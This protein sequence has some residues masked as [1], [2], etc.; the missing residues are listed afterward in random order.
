[1]DPDSTD[2]IDKRNQNFLEE[3]RQEITNGTAI[4]PFLGSGIS[5]SSGI[6]TGQ[7]FDNYL[8]YV[9]FR[10]LSDKD[11]WDVRRD[12]WPETPTHQ[13]VNDATN[14]LFTVYGD[15]LR[16]YDCV[17]ITKFHAES[18]LSSAASNVPIPA[19]GN[20]KTDEK[21]NTDGDRKILHVVSR[22]FE[23]KVLQGTGVTI[24]AKGGRMILIH[25]NDEDGPLAI[26]V[27]EEEKPHPNPPLH[28][29]I[30]RKPEHKYERNESIPRIEDAELLGQ[31]NRH[32]ANWWNLPLPER[33]KADT[34][35]LL[36][37]MLRPLQEHSTKAKPA[38][39]AIINLDD[40]NIPAPSAYRL[41][42]KLKRPLVPIILRSKE[43]WRDEI[44]FDQIRRDMNLED[45]P[46]DPNASASSVSYVT[47]KAIR[48]LSH[49][50][51]TLEFLSCIRPAEK[52]YN[53]W[54]DEPET[55]VIDSFNAHITRDRHPNLIHTMIARLSRNLRSRTILTTNFDTLIEQAFLA[56][57][58][59]LQVFAV[60][61]KG[62]LPHHATVRAQD[63]I[64]KLHG[65]ILET[66]AD[67]TI[68]EP[69]NE[70]DKERFFNYLRGGNQP[71]LEQ[72]REFI[73]SHLLVI[74]YSGNDARCIRMIKYVLDMDA[75]FRVFWICYNKDDEKRVK[76]L[77]SE[78]QT[79]TIDTKRPR[80]TIARTDQSDLFLW[81]LYQLINFSLPGG[82]VSFQFAH[83]IPPQPTLI[84]KDT[85]NAAKGEPE[86][87]FQKVLDFITETSHSPNISRLLTVD[88]GSGLAVDMVKAFHELSA[89]S[90]QPI[91]LELEDF[92]DADHLANTI[93][94]SISLKIGTFQT[95]WHIYPNSRN[96]KLEFERFIN[97]WRIDADRWVL[98][99]YARNGPGGCCGWTLD[100]WDSEKYERL[101]YLLS[102]LSDLNFR[103]IYLPFGTKRFER[104]KIKAS[105]I[106]N[107]PGIEK[108]HTDFSR[109]YNAWNRLSR[110]STY[111]HNPVTIPESAVD[112]KASLES[113]TYTSGDSTYRSILDSVL[114]EFGSSANPIRSSR[115]IWLYGM[116]LFR[117]SRH[118]T[119]VL[120][121]SV[122]PCPSRFGT[123]FDNDEIRS[124]ILFGL[125]DD[126]HRAGVQEHTFS[127]LRELLHQAGAT[128]KIELQ[129][130]VEWLTEKGLI[131]KKAGGYSW[132]YRDTRLGIQYLLENS[133][134]YTFYPNAL[135][136]GLPKNQRSD[137]SRT[138]DS[139]WRLRG[140]IHYWI[141][142][143]YLRAF[144]A[145]RHHT[146]LIEAIYHSVQSLIHSP[147]G[148][149]D[150]SPS[151]KGV[152]NR[153]P[154]SRAQRNAL[155]AL[156]Q[157][158]KLIRLGTNSLQFWTPGIELD[159]TYFK[160]L[161]EK[162][163]LLETFKIRTHFGTSHPLDKRIRSEYA[164]VS[165]EL[166][167]LCNS[168]ASEGAAH[169]K[170]SEDF[171]KSSR[172]SKRVE[173]IE[174]K[175]D[176]KTVDNPKWFQS[177]V[178]ELE[179]LGFPRL[180]RLIRRVCIEASEDDSGEFH[181]HC[182][183]ESFTRI[184]SIIIE[185]WAEKSCE[186]GELLN[187]VW[188]L[189]ELAYRSARRATLIRFASSKSPRA[190]AE[191]QHW[192]LTSGF[193]HLCIQ[194]LRIVSARQFRQES[195]L[196]VQ[197]LTLYGLA[198]GYLG[199]YK[200][201]HRRFNEAHAVLS[202]GVSRIDGRDLAKIHIRRA[203]LILARG[204]EL[205]NLFRSSKRKK[206]EE[207]EIRA[208]LACCDD[209]WASLE[210]A[211]HG[212][213]DVHHSCFWWYRF[214]VLELKTYAFF[215][216]IEQVFWRGPDRDTRRSGALPFR[217]RKPLDAV[218]VK[219]L[220][221]CISLSSGD[222]FR[223]LR[224]FDHFLSACRLL[225][226]SPGGALR[227]IQLNRKT[228]VPE[229]CLSES[230]G[231]SHP[232]NSAGRS[233]PSGQVQLDPDP[234]GNLQLNRDIAAAWKLASLCPAGS[235]RKAYFDRVNDFVKRT[236]RTSPA[237]R[238][239]GKELKP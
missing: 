101:H 152:N 169:G 239:S 62:G 78:Y 218:L 145:T 63:C 89:K 193:C 6:L 180:Q 14:W 151:R 99:L 182:L 181:G 12:G 51:R 25:R 201:G 21:R 125:G 191:L 170:R 38:M 97:R 136:V 114:K 24:P 82:G 192:Q 234:F 235:Y 216:E 15:C 50:T 105:A 185:D 211:S 197:V 149:Q 177:I 72:P 140:R 237:R 134:P 91:W 221:D 48:S 67:S 113:I 109:S 65:D 54:L 103:V 233:L 202:A 16:R 76:D 26:Y 146:P 17:A 188:L 205:L 84:K 166:H 236:F 8:T 93:I 18:A 5:V 31:L 107:Y 167:L 226:A 44:R 225:N 23:V 1:M 209:A 85:A 112:Q 2:F 179:R 59:R 187:L 94:T 106:E 55:A 108:R 27:Y 210:R 22:I 160:G 154:D 126:H 95:H 124:L 222:S 77:F 161:G 74:G 120:S 174:I 13:E 110:P 69:P 155:R 224:A 20:G 208:I 147:Y 195:R 184:R 163:N 238:N 133:G 40:P 75:R 116:T 213:R 196:R 19:N 158:G 128:K 121:E 98:F 53:A 3:I 223:F 207:L 156:I 45:Q 171:L 57:G 198:L 137:G 204:R 111:R 227:I 148:S 131:L 71:H 173:L 34:I 43:I 143:W 10:C 219:L 100:Y 129:G 87:P 117:Q 68:N 127:A 56:Q 42:I 141:G 119:A 135:S 183:Y 165:R 142:D 118:R 33:T 168:V 58:E 159:M 217:R 80:I 36:Q 175:H 157:L 200:E 164:L 232:S 199:R 47:E 228:G 214:H 86:R 123:G 46:F 115:M 150:T 176:I 132:K 28:F 92:A 104:N 139:I 79:L 162:G 64:V 96:L 215:A 4:T 60:S 186:D 32:L 83:L 194:L 30:A 41:N 88:V 178:S 138:Y 90:L 49:W 220:R 144:Q 229:V 130:W 39:D 52:A 189:S 206:G 102:I 203:E 70:A 190:S 29:V 153:R 37:G 35:H 81:E 61:A 9:V 66:R 231:A 122:F 172:Q 73:P 11:P 212:M 230:D 7:D